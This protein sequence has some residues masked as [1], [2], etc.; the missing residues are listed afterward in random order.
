MFSIRWWMGQ[1][2]S[3]TPKRHVGY[4]NTR[5]ISWLN[6]GQL[7]WDYSSPKYKENRT[8]KRSGG[9][10]QK[11]RFTGVKKNLKQSQHLNKQTLVNIAVPYFH[12][13]PRVGYRLLISVSHVHSGKK[14]VQGN[15]FKFVFM[16]LTR[17][18]V[19]TILLRL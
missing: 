2:G 5:A 1:Y 13:L 7:R 18:L 3:A 14:P 10:G 4:S 8:T 16:S 12:C 9:R 6:L 19:Q 15:Q 17:D 11:K